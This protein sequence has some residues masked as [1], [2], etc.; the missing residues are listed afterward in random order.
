[1]EWILALHLIFVIAWF[2]GLFYLPRLFV[3]HVG[4]TDTLS[5]QRF[6]TMERKLCYYI[7]LPAAILATFFGL[8]LL[9]IMP[10]LL[11]FGWMHWK[12]ICVGLLWVFQLYCMRMVSQFAHDKNP[13]SERFYRFFNEIPTVLLIAII[14][15]AI[16]Q[17]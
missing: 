10:M 12:L 2:A 16:V 13:H 17:P 11:D 1:M 5:N 15:F 14:I 7:M 8:W 4:A 9:Y 6:K 3:Y